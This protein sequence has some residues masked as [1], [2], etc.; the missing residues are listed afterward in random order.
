M[1]NKDSSV[2]RI[3]EAIIL[4]RGRKVLLDGYL[5][6]LYG[7]ATKR[8]NEQIKRNAA[9]FPTDFMFRITDQELANL[10]SQIATSSFARPWGGR[11]YRPFV[12]TEHGAVM[13]ANVLNS[14]RAIEV[15]VFVVRAFVRLR[16]GF[17]A[18][19]ELAGRLDDLERKIAALSSRQDDLSESTRAQFKHVIDALRQ[20]MAPTPASA[21][22]PIGFVT[23]RE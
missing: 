21:K 23:P 3:S 16:E 5:A 2:D 10:R 18:H 22:R 4:L 17:A 1:A 14:P 13:A 20:L 9:R 8:F 12:F 6:R 11:R 7:V 19:G 15:S